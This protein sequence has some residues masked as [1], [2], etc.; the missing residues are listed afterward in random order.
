MNMQYSNGINSKHVK[1]VCGNIQYC[2]WSVYWLCVVVV[3]RRKDWLLENTCI[4]MVQNDVR[5]LT[6]LILYH[7]VQSIIAMTSCL[8]FGNLHIII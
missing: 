3:C 2:Q 1:R 4:F 8:A 7:S 5:I 6:I